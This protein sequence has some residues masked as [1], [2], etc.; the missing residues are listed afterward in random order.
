MKS[1]KEVYDLTEKTINVALKRSLEL[2]INDFVIASCT[3]KTVE[4]FLKSIE[5]F[6]KQGNGKCLMG[7]P[8]VKNYGLNIVCVTHQVGFN[9]PNQDE[10][11]ESVREKLFNNGV[12]ILTTTH[13]LGGIDRALRFQFKGIYPAEIVSSSLRMLGQGLKV[14]LEISVMATDAGLMKS[15]SNLIA[16]G[17][18]SF[19]ADTSAVI[20]PTHSQ[21]IFETKIREII[22]KPFEF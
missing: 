1:Q 7:E 22:C 8:P 10:M 16:I 17:G 12:K 15:G 6:G 11:Q 5:N 4:I 3:G 18:T 20:C 2:H 14:C 21:T 13:L 9:N 19:G